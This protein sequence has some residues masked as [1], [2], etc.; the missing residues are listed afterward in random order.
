MQH[1]LGNLWPEKGIG[2]A[3]WE[4]SRPRTTAAIGPLVG[5]VFSLLILQGPREG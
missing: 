5:E 1:L 4:K 3:H 2:V